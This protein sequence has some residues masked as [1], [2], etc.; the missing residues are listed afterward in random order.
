MWVVL[1]K[2]L[3]ACTRDGWQSIETAQ[4]SELSISYA[5]GFLVKQDVTSVTLSLL[6]ALEG[7]HCS[8]WINIPTDNI[9]SMQILTKVD[10]NG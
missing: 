7:R 1:I 10:I 4:E 9:V 3:D 8:P 6:I 2:W 5:V